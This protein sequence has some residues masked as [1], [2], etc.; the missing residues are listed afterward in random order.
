MVDVSPAPP[1]SPLERDLWRAAGRQLKGTEERAAAK[2][3]RRRARKGEA[4]RRTRGA[5][6][7]MAQ[8][9]R[10]RRKEERKAAAAEVREKARQKARQRA[11]RLFYLF[12]FDALTGLAAV[13]YG[14][15]IASQFVEPATTAV[16]VALTYGSLLLG[17]AFAGLVG[18]CSARCRRLGLAVSANMAPLIAAFYLVLFLLVLDKAASNTFLAYLTEHA[19]VLYLDEV[20]IDVL[21]RLLPFSCIMLVSLAATQVCRFLLLRHLREK[22]LELDAANQRRAE[23]RGTI[24]EPLLD[25]EGGGNY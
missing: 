2:A 17:A 12:L 15:L 24:R 10:E 21:R 5:A 9:V 19:E 13:V 14:A 6:G 22:M 4:R 25:E 1:V 7:L 23:S 3:R 11:A 16:A 18:F 20:E 8:A